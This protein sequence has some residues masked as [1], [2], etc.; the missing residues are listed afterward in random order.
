MGTVLRIKRTTSRGQIVRYRA[1]YKD[2]SGAWRSKTFE[3]QADARAFLVEA[4]SDV[5]KGLH[6]V[7]RDSVTVREAAD[8][9]LAACERGRAGR[10]PVEEQTLRLYRVLTRRHIVPVLGAQ[11][12]TDLSASRVKQFRDRD[13]IDAGRSR[14]LTK[15]ALA[16]LS[17]ICRE[18]IADELLNVNPCAAIRL[19]SGGRHKARVQIPTKEQV[20]TLLETARQWTIDPPKWPGGEYQAPSRKRALWFYTLL[21]FLVGTGV[22]LSEARGASLSALDLGGEKFTVRQRADER[23]KIG[24]PK[25]AAGR[26]TIELYPGLVAQLRAWLAEHPSQEGVATDLLFPNTAGRAES[27]SNIYKRFWLPLLV[28]CGLARRDEAGRHEVEFTIHALRHFFVSVMIEAGVEPKALSELVGHASI[29]MTMDVYGH[30][31]A[32]DEA[33]ARRRRMADALAE[34]VAL[35]VLETASRAS[36]VPTS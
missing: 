21:A 23:G 11:R 26:R 8:R 36:V 12:L 22:R 20:R 19:V 14:V 32:D 9:W 29:T 33:I 7:D 34:T 16:A 27:A 28:S 30:L 18:A 3:R 35:P 15:K 10:P 4:E 2:A 5:S 25:S 24:A 13:M 6:V 1:S 31:F 17:A